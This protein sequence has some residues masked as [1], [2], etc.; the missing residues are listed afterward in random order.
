MGID[1]KN[2]SRYNLLIFLRVPLIMNVGKGEWK[3]V[4][5]GRRFP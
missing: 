4:E 2:S 5:E 3:G 1:R